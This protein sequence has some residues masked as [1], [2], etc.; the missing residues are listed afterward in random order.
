MMG[1]RK[2]AVRTILDMLD[3]QHQALLS[4]NL[5][6]LGQMAPDLERAFERLGREGGSK[7]EVTLIKE[8][9]VRNARLMTA[10]QAGV[11]TARAHLQ[12]SRST[13]LTTY[14]AHGR[15][16]AGASTQSRTL[17]RR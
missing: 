8:C 9:A 5:E 16:H 3:A 2:P 17:A 10:A 6:V 12:S 15:S 4:G 7:A 11:A 14:D 13:H 1:L